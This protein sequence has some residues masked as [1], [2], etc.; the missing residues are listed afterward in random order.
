MKKLP[1]IIATLTLIVI[2]GGVFFFTKNDSAKPSPLPSPNGYEFFWGEGCPHCKNVEDFLT[3]WDK[4]DQI[5]L[6]Q[7]EIYQNQTNAQ[8]FTQRAN[9]CG[10]PRAQQGVP[11][12]VTPEGKCIVGDTPIIDYLKNL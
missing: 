7:K 5:V 11:L 8:E 9:A 2:V 4:K 10:I 1:V 6:S 3:T 12:L